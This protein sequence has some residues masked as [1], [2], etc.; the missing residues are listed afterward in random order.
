MEKIKNEH[1]I[2]IIPIHYEHLKK[3][4]SSFD[5]LLKLNNSLNIKKNKIK[6]D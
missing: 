5:Y 3:Q 4:N 1:K 2:D 6:K